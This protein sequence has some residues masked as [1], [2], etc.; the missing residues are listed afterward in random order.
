[1]NGLGDRMLAGRWGAFL[2][3]I[4]I[5]GGMLAMVAMVND[6]M[7]DWRIHAVALLIVGA[8][9]LLSR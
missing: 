8:V 5:I 7:G 3:G 9:L 2:G 6:S 1:M 4:A